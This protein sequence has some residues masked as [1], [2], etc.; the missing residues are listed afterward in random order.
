MK[1]ID[2]FREWDDDGNGAIDK[3]EFRKAIAGL[4]YDA[5]RKDIDELF[6][7]LDDTGDGLIEYGELKAALSKHS[8]KVKSKSKAAPAK[9]KSAKSVTGEAAELKNRAELLLD[10]VH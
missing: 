6:K 4:G 7:M 10:V 8:K 2:L 3:K 5:P 1:L 9:S